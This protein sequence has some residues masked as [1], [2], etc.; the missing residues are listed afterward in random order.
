MTTDY[1][2]KLMDLTTEK[3]FYKH[4]KSEYELLRFRL[5]IRKYFTNL[6]EI[7]EWNYGTNNECKKR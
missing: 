2:I 5:Q 4:C 6:I 1:K 3:T 7:K